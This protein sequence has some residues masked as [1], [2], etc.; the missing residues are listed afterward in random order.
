MKSNILDS[1][2]V[3]YFRSLCYNIVKHDASRTE[4]RLIAIITYGEHMEINEL[5]MIADLYKVRIKVFWL[6][7]FANTFSV[8]QMA[9]LKTK[10]FFY[11]CLV[12]YR[13]EMILFYFLFF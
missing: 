3:T 4:D 8:S 13:D 7:I 6:K 5:V 11:H 12:I 2:L 9:H 1:I 10:S